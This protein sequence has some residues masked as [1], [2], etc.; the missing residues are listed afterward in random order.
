MDCLCEKFSQPA[1]CK[2]T[3]RSFAG[4]RQDIRIINR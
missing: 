4:R 3:G 2:K 1:G